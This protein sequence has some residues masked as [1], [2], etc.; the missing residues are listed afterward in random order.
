MDNINNFKDLFES[1][2]D[3]RNIVL[4]IFLFQNDNNLL[5]EI[6]FSERDNNRLKL[7]LKKIAI[8][9]YEE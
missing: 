8:E 9:Q 4:F 3:Y 2:P 1:I 5:R 6:G 7:L